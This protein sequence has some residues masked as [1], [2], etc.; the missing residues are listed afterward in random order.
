MRK[1]PTLQCFLGVM[2]RLPYL[3]LYLST[4]LGRYL[5]SGHGQ[6]YMG[7]KSMCLHVN[8]VLALGIN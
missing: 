6:L 3:G 5:G 4:Y 7:S 2:W 8:L 1:A